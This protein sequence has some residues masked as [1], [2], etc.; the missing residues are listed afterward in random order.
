MIRRPP[1]STLFPYTTLFRSNE[2][3]AGEVSTILGYL[4]ALQR[5]YNLAVMVTHHARKNGSATGGLSLRGS[6]D[7]FAW[8][9]TAL[10]L[11]RRQHT[12]LLSVEHRAAAAPDSLTLA[13]LGTEQDM[14][15]SIVHAEE[16]AAPATADLDAMILD[17]LEHA[18]QIGRAHV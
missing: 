11:R 3:Q 18:G 14:H 9:D 7:F 8:V 2:N 4:R 12:L 16:P 17:A 10:S 15:L 13:L 5:T 6:G 1:R